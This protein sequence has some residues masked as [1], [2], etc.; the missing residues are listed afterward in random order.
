MKSKLPKNEQVT[1]LIATV[2]ADGQAA[3]E[4]AETCGWVPGSGCCRRQ[5]TL[6]CSAECFFRGMRLAEGNAILQRRRRR[7]RMGRPSTRG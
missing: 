7:R 3:H 6:E 2:L 4:W 5:R 1:D